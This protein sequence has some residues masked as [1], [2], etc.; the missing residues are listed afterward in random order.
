MVRSTAIS[1]KIG[2]AIAALALPVGQLRALADDRPTEKLVTRSASLEPKT[3]Q[4]ILLPPAS[5]AVFAS[6]RPALLD[7]A[8]IIMVRPAKKGAIAQP[9]S[10]A[11][12]T[13]VDSTVV[14]TPSMPEQPLRAEILE[15]ATVEESPPALQQPPRV[16]LL[17]PVSDAA[18]SPALPEKPQK[19]AMPIVN[20]SLPV[21]SPFRQ[22]AFKSEIVE[23]APKDVATLQQQASEPAP[24]K[25]NAASR[26]LAKLWPGDKDKSS[27]TANAGETASLVPPAASASPSNEQADA[28][29]ENEKPP[30][31][32]FLDGIQFWKN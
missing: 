10:E 13:Q 11:A 6:K 28:G 29:P 26:F 12:E 31:K 22:T 25:G 7:E 27:T 20:P 3:V 19:N 8:P 17:P 15:D 18:S 4:I 14:E 5:D 9:L 1:W 30:I 32:R 21:R 16:A 24:A 2:L 23:N